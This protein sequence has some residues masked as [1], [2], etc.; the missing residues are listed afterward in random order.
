M[1]S[2]RFPF[3]LSV[4]L[5][6]FVA[7]ALPALADS[8]TIAKEPLSPDGAEIVNRGKVI[9]AWNCYGHKDVKIHGIN[10][11]TEPAGHLQVK[12][13][14]GRQAIDTVDSEQVAKRYPSSAMQTLMGTYPRSNWNGG[15]QL[16]VTGLVEGHK[17]TAQF[18]FDSQQTALQVLS[19]GDADG[20]PRIGSFNA[21]D[22]PVIITIEFTAQATSQQFTIKAAKDQHGNSYRAVLNAMCVTT[23]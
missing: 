16:V 20:K 18:L 11:K 10:F 9:A 7:I 15:Y 8:D 23:R 5:T 13:L 2:S 14:G 22:Q 6:M 12:Y 21:K 4:M 3:T 17:Y 1:R 19:L